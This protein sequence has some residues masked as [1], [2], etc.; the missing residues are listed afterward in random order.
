MFAGQVNIVSQLSCGTSAILNYFCP[1]RSPI[2][3]HVPL[4]GHHDDVLFE[5]CHQ[6]SWSDTKIDNYIIISSLKSES[7]CKLINRIPGLCLMI[8]SLPG[9]ALRTHV[10][11][12]CKASRMHVESLGKP[13]DSTSVLEVLPVKLDIKRHSPVF[14]IYL[15]LWSRH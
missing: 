9:K 6:W 3:W 10:E 1:L 2:S 14:S 4:S 7:T 15:D 12:L 13:S 11:S 5:F 8:S